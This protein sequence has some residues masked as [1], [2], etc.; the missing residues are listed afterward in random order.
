MFL[1]PQRADYCHRDD[2]VGACLF[3]IDPSFGLPLYHLPPLPEKSPIP[4]SERLLH[5]IERGGKTYS[6][7][8]I[9]SLFYDFFILN[10]II[11]TKMPGIFDDPLFLGMQ[12]NPISHRLIESSKK[13][14]TPAES[15]CCLAAMVYLAD[16]RVEFLA[17]NVTG[18]HYIERLKAAVLNSEWHDLHDLRLWAL[19]IG[20]IKS[21]EKDRYLFIDA[22]RITMGDLGIN[23]W[24]Q[25]TEIVESIIWIDSVYGMRCQEFGREVMAGY[26]RL[27]WRGTGRKE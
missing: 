9:M 26:S 15:T 1:Q 20:G 17:Y 4:P 27:G 6:N 12:I 24:N 13:A 3:D 21:S 2:V 25:V 19:V 23:T 22:T 16:I 7:H 10:S 5:I 11:R 14:T 18:H 8:Q